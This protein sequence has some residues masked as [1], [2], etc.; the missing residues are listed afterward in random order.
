MTEPVAPP[1]LVNFNPGQSKWAKWSSNGDDLGKR[2]ANRVL[3]TV[4][5]EK[6]VFGSEHSI[7]FTTASYSV[8][9]VVRSSHCTKHT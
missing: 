7:G 1:R 8:Q 9:L 5:F 3:V 6:M 2:D 4:G